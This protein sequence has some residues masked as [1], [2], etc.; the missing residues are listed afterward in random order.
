MGLVKKGQN[1]VVTAISNLGRKWCLGHTPN[2]FY[3]VKLF[4]RKNIF[5]LTFRKKIIAL[6]NF[7]NLGWWPLFELQKWRMGCVG[8]PKFWKSRSCNPQKIRAKY[9]DLTPCGSGGNLSWTIGVFSSRYR[10]LGI[11]TFGEKMFELNMRWQPSTRAFQ[12]LS[13]AL[14]MRHSNS[15]YC[16]SRK[17]TLISKM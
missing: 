12:T 10:S 1:C 11:R 8:A 7:E 16:I 9:H 4:R 14:S 2:F 15:T 13:E 5:H 3:R 17:Q 6:E